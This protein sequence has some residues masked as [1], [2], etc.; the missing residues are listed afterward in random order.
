MHE[1]SN[2]MNSDAAADKDKL[3]CCDLDLDLEDED[4]LWFDPWEGQIE[5]L[6]NKADL[7]M[8]SK[9]LLEHELSLEEEF[10]EFPKRKTLLLRHTTTSVPNDN[11]HSAHTL[12]WNHQCEEDVS[13]EVL[14][15]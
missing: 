10:E 1:L 13:D 3:Y 11:F 2:D 8:N 6:T 12:F 4:Q 14:S 5:L 7:D 15:S 9:S